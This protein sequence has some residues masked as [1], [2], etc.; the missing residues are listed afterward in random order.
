MAATAS[1]AAD[2][3][4]QKYMAESVKRFS[5]SIELCD[6]YLRGY[7]GLKLTVL[8]LLGE[9]NK[10]VKTTDAEDLV[11]P[12]TAT[13]QR[14]SELATAKLSEIVRLHTAGEPRWQGY[15]EAE[16]AAAQALLVKEVPVIAR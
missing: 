1:G 4:Y 3:T 2:A 12:D 8:R 9:S 7:Y 11:L 5:R 16:V 15:E 6:N 10:P 13:L 14:L